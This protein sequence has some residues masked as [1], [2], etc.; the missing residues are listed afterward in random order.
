MPPA[1][2]RPPSNKR[3]ASTS[4]D[5][6]LTKTPRATPTPPPPPRL[7][8]FTSL[9]FALA[10]FPE[11]DEDGL[12]ES[13]VKGGAHVVDGYVDFSAGTVTHLLC[14]DSEDDNASEARRAGVKVVDSEWLCKR[15]AEAKAEQLSTVPAASEAHA[16]SSSFGKL[17]TIV[18]AGLGSASP[19]T[20]RAEPSSAPA[21]PAAAFAAAAS[22]GGACGA[23]E[24]GATADDEEGENDPE[25]VAALPRLAAA[26]YD[27]EDQTN[28][29]A[30]T[31]DD[32]DGDGGG[33]GDASRGQPPHQLPQSQPAP[34]TTAS[35]LDAPAARPLP[36]EHTLPSDYVDA[37]DRE[38]VRMPCSP[39]CLDRRT[40][41]P[42]WTTL[43]RKLW[44]PPANTLA[45]LNALSEIRRGLRGEW[46]FEG[47][48]EFLRDELSVG[49]RSTFFS[50]TLPHLC[51]LALR[52]PALFTSPLP[53]LLRGRAKRVCLTPEQCGCLLA[54]AFFCSF[55]YRADSSGGGGGGGG[56]RQ[57]AAAALPS[58]TF[59]VLHGRM[60]PPRHAGSHLNATQPHKWRCL[61]RYFEV[62]ARRRQ[63][64]AA[65]PPPPLPLPAAPGAA[66]RGGGG[67][68][69]DATGGQASRH[70][71]RGA[72]VALAGFDDDDAEDIRNE[73]CLA[74]AQVLPADAT[75]TAGCT[76]L[77]CDEASCP[78]A[79]KKV[80]AA[81]AEATRLGV[82]VVGPAWFSAATS[83]TADAEEESGDG[84]APSYPNPT[85]PAPPAS[86]PP[87]APYSAAPG[88]GTVRFERLVLDTSDYELE[89]FWCENTAPLCEVHPSAEGSI[90]DMGCGVLHLDFA[91][92]WIGGGVLGN[93]SV[94]EEIRFLICPELI[95]SRLLCERMEANEA[96]LMQG[97]ERFSCYGGY[98]RTFTCAEPYDDIP[99]PSRRPALIAIDATRYQHSDP[100][101][102]FRHAELERELNKALAGFTPP[103]DHSTD[104]PF[105]S[106]AS[107]SASSASSSSAAAL[108]PC[109]AT[110]PL[111]TGNWGCG[112]F[113]GDLQLKALLQLLAASAARRT[114]MHYLTFGD[115]DLAEQLGRLV[116]R[117]RAIGCTCG[118]LAKVLKAFKPWKFPP[119]PARRGTPGSFANV[120]RYIHGRID[121]HEQTLLTRNSVAR[122]GEHASERATPP[123]ASSSAAV[124]APTSP[125]ETT[126]LTRALEE[127]TDGQRATATSAQQPQDEEQGALTED[128]EE[129]LPGRKHEEMEGQ[130]AACPDD[131]EEARTEAMRLLD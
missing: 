81:V 49:E 30:K 58:F 103:A 127:D 87:L 25:L 130:Q 14:D 12:R 34:P 11:E 106:S 128:D 27:D 118:Q 125:H 40:G 23:S 31:E 126:P 66:G 17:R 98:A 78:E 19:A 53:L 13:L 73:L 55:P 59:A 129:Q 111:C 41:Q 18:D 56:R 101:R 54:H 112:A 32:S 105:A 4:L 5:T 28:E 63:A 82:E 29:Q 97:F 69:F 20:G 83:A 72:T 15:L 33:D 80:A 65:T 51:S 110:M 8:P 116:G 77:L 115:D 120:F 119:D 24:V 9:T 91:N 109:Y 2:S 7:Q 114:G 85:R 21:A 64:E 108:A 107:S 44:P 93:G 46:T 68:G 70:Q 84:G 76:H 48:V 61:L 35:Q 60:H 131:E 100:L 52:M 113:G 99:D 121:M 123:A 71:L 57:A 102:Q 79:A 122:E 3:P 62:L 86:P 67:G 26:E 43:C 117:L 1:S 37:W 89:A 45:L 22:G 16:A 90:E 92:A 50:L 88:R 42:L 6:W 94:Q 96:I 74:G 124:A 95:V 47:F 38:H 75:V 104:N 39:R 36:P 10:G